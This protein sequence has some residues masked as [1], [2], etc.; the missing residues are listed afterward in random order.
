MDKEKK[1]IK[2]KYKKNVDSLKKYIDE[3]NNQR[4]NVKFYMNKSNDL[5][6]KLCAFVETTEEPKPYTHL[7]KTDSTHFSSSQEEGL[8]KP[9]K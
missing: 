8:H 5:E 1:E 7:G 2:E 3:S 6:E 9:P 4:S